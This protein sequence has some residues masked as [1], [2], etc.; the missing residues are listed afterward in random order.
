MAFVE[1]YGSLQTQKYVAS[2]ISRYVEY[3]LKHNKP[4]ML[5]CQIQCYSGY[6][7]QSNPTLNAKVMKSRASS[8]HKLYFS[9]GWQVIETC[10]FL[11]AGRNEWVASKMS[12]TVDRSMFSQP[13]SQKTVEHF[14]LGLGRSGAGSVAHVPLRLFRAVR[15]FG[16]EFMLLPLTRA[17]RWWHEVVGFVNASILA[18]LTS[19]GWCN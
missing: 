8:C 12:I 18:R 17:I 9:Q 11:I 19:I 4:S 5:F 7:N 16:R 3:S 13:P 2:F 14:V 1:V 10:R 15:L 6:H